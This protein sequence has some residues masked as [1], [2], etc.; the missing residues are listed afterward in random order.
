MMVLRLALRLPSVEEL[1]RL[2]IADFE[3][4]AQRVAEARAHREILAKR[5]AEAPVVDINPVRDAPPVPR[6]GPRPPGNVSAGST[7]MAFL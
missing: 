7:L 5:V 2:Q 3:L 4:L 1:P 6:P